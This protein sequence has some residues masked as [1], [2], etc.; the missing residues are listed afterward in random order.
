MHILL[1]FLSVKF[2]LPFFLPSLPS[3]LP[4]SLPFFLLSLPSSP[5]S[6]LPSFS[7]LPP[8]LLLS[9]LS[10]SLLLS[11]LSHF[12]LLSVFSHSL[13]LFFA[14][15]SPGNKHD[16]LQT[17]DVKSSRTSWPRGQNFVLVIVLVLEDLSSALALSICRRYVLELFIW[18]FWNCLM[19]AL[20]IFLS[21]QWLVN[22]VTYLL[23]MSMVIVMK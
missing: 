10:H 13:L 20:V 16:R 12:L 21:L 19:L 14:L 9:V 6:H 22:C 7:S 1:F 4:S 2:F 23:I 5:C 3:Y 17:S 11:V 18:A 15:A 8:F